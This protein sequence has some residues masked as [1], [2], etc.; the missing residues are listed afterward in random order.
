MSLYLACVAE[1]ALWIHPGRL[2]VYST[3]LSLSLSLSCLPLQACVGVRQMLI[4][5]HFS[6]ESRAGSMVSNVFSYKEFTSE[7]SL[8]Y[9]SR[10]KDFSGTL[11]RCAYASASFS[12]WQSP[13]DGS[14]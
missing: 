1:S 3:P 9:W 4:P 10:S 7:C 14:L 2:F 13:W 6:T 8:R 12:S 11:P 5:T